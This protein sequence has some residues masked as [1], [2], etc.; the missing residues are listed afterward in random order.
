MYIFWNHYLFL[1]INIYEVAHHRTKADLHLSSKSI[2]KIKIIESRH[3]IK[4]RVVTS[5]QKG[6]S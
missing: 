3:L 6:T 5:I 4:S 2:D 1:A